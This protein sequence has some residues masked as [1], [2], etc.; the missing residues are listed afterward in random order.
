M[1]NQ[2]VSE[3]LDGPAVTALLQQA[4]IKPS[5]HRV[6]IGES[7]FNSAA[8]PTADM[9]LD[10]VRQ[11][12]PLVS[13]ATIYN[14]LNL[15]VEKGLLRELSLSPGRVVFD[16]NLAPH[17]HFIDLETGEIS[18]IPWETL[19]VSGVDTLD[20]VDV[21]SCQVLIHGRRRTAMG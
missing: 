20:H 14:T 15:F 16:P 8:H 18:D 12:F 21:D 9:V 5:D 11:R 13:R 6:A 4:G 3:P 2:S 17:H 1:N 10:A 7:V 19:N